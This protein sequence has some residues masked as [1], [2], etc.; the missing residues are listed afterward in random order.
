MRKP[1]RS[2]GSTTAVTSSTGRRTDMT[3]TEALSRL[4]VKRRETL[5]PEGE[6]PMDDATF[7]DAARAIGLALWNDGGFNLMVAVCDEYRHTMPRGFGRQLEIYWSG[8]G[9]F[10]S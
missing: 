4:R 1:A 3:R 2:G 6:A 10:Q 7:Y 9:T 5:T 8:I